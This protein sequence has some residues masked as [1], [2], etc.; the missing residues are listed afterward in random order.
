MNMDDVAEFSRHVFGTREFRHKGDCGRWC[1]I[2]NW[3]LPDLTIYSASPDWV[4]LYHGTTLHQ[5]RDILEAGFHLG[6]HHRHTK[7]SP[8]GLW[9]TDHPGHSFDRCPLNRGFSFNQGSTPRL[10]AWDC[11]VALCWT[12]HQ[13]FLKGKTFAGWTKFCMRGPE[14]FMLDVKSSRTEIWIH[15]DVYANFNSLEVLWPRI[16]DGELHVCR[17]RAGTP[18]DLYKCGDMNQM[19]CGSC[20]QSRIARRCGWTRAKNSK[21]WTCHR[22]AKNFQGQGRSSHA[23]E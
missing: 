21:K 10:N 4:R 18:E 1:V 3:Y 15:R 14:D 23:L 16:K 19:T 12:V 17:A 9:G 8:C 11:P 7:S 2:S 6:R 13:S 5:A 22:C 20:V